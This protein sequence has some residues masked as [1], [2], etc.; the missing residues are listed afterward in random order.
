MQ[1][2][3]GS[4]TVLTSP[5]RL[6][7]ITVTVHSIARGLIRLGPRFQHA[8]ARR[9]TAPGGTRDPGQETIVTQRPADALGG[10]QAR[11]RVGVRLRRKQLR[12]IVC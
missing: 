5:L 10:T 7:W 1:V 11:E 8:L 4:I 2:P 12:K 6:S 9:R 3:C